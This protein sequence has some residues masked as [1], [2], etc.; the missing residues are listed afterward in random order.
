M[1][2]KM[3]KG[4]IMENV[5]LDGGNNRKKRTIRELLVQVH[6][7]IVERERLIVEKRMHGPDSTTPQWYS[8]TK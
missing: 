3:V 8:H 6:K 7:E 1:N 2:Q 4:I 5:T